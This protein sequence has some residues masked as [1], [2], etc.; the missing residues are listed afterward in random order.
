MNKRMRKKGKDK[1]NRCKKQQKTVHNGY[2]TPCG[3][4]I[5]GPIRAIMKKFIQDNKD[6]PKPLILLDNTGL[7]WIYCGQGE[8]GGFRSSL[9]HWSE[10]VLEPWMIV[11][12]KLTF[13]LYEE[14]LCQLQD[15]Q[16]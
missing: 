7:H 8:F 16:I 4:I 11:S 9:G 1:C 14:E 6:H 10:A 12:K 15:N 5:V 3:K 13:K 2:C